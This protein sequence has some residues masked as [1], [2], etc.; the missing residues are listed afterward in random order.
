MSI[1]KCLD[2]FKRSFDDLSEDELRDYARSVLQKASEY[3][4]LTGTAAI[5]KAQG[6]IGKEFEASFYENAQISI[7]NS[8]KLNYIVDKLNSGK[9]NVRDFVGRRYDGKADNIE[10]SQKSYV[11]KLMGRFFN[12][13]NK[14]DLAY[15]Q[16][17][18]NQMEIAES[19]DGKKSSP[20]SE[21]IA[22]SLK[23]YIQERNIVLTNTNALKL[24][25]INK[26]RYLRAVHDANSL[27]RGGRSIIKE[28]MK[29]GKITRS[30]SKQEWVD[31]IKQH[32]DMDKTFSHTDAMI[33]DEDDLVAMKVDDRA[34]DGI[35]NNVFDNIVTGKSEIFTKSKVVNDAE[36]V[37]K[38]SRS[39]FVWKDLA[40]L[41]KYN[42]KYGHGDLF[43]SILQ[44]IQSSGSKAGTADR[45]G[46]DAENTYQQL[47][48]AQ[49]EDEDKP[50]SKFWWRNTDL[51]MKEVMKSN[52]TEVSP[53]LANFGANLRSFSGMAR[54][55]GIVL[56]SITDMHFA[57]AYAQRWG[58]NYFRSFANQF[59]SLFNQFTN[60][61]K[62]QFASMMHLQLK[63]HIGYLGK[64]ADTENLGQATNKIS[65]KYYRAIGMT[66]WDNGNRIG[67]M[68][69]IS[70]RLGDMSSKQW[71]G[72]PE[73]TQQQLQKFGIERNE[74]EAIRHHSENG[75]LS[76]DAV[77]K[78][79]NDDLRK[80]HQE[81]GGTVPYYNLRNDLYRKLYTLHD[82]AAE[83]A[84][85]TPSTWIRSMMNQDTNSGTV[86]GEAV[87]MVMQFKG[88]AFS[89][90]DRALLEGF[91]NA[92]G[93]TAKLGHALQQFG[94]V[95][96]L[97][98]LS[99][100]F[101]FLSQGKSMPDPAKMSVGQ[102]IN[103]FAGVAAPGIGIF[104][105]VL[106]PRNQNQDMVSSFLLTP[107]ARLLGSAAGTVLSTAEGNFKG[108][109]KNLSKS[110]Q[111][112]VPSSAVPGASPYVKQ[113]LG[114]HPFL[115][116]GQQQL[117]G[118]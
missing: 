92:D 69:T 6:E 30:G 32:L 26:D 42:E 65:A 72:L 73:K 18:D 66:A 53:R 105:T 114:E 97:S 40:S 38:L 39:F 74:W 63:S 98:Y 95:L 116:P 115:M 108:A 27:L 19:F 81:N 14:E 67:I 1:N 111:Y 75:L 23:D 56:S 57:A 84:I 61:E 118:G 100:Y 21:K 90:I 43:S 109:G 104:S 77:D 99:T 71:G 8:N 31:F 94:G 51:F 49:Q 36:A 76:L 33:Q 106:D 48:R 80:L 37:K 41:V 85:L 24:D 70:K 20:R 47:R 110:L 101:Y 60:D 45:F 3:K 112:L 58:I 78:L 55:P 7:N 34:A 25:Y 96:P 102:N 12:R 2:I 11:N 9:L 113:F 44:D 29:K 86:L 54:L 87:R 93:A 91:S 79:T 5:K 10:S 46:S 59:E 68:H 52:K 17:G 50:S 62:K 89:Y 107:S 83:N 64:F 13:L 22:N 88:F 117:Y 103:F 28:A 15:L 82:V 35:L 16:D 4:D